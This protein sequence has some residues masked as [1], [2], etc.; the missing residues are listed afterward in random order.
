LYFIKSNKKDK[1]SDLTNIQQP[2]LFRI[3]PL[4]KLLT[5]NALNALTSN[6][7]VLHSEKNAAHEWIE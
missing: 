3:E 6:F 5:R 2:G 1:L 4:Q 7:S